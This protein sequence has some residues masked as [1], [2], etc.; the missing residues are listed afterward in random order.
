MLWA[1]MSLFA[2]H[3]APT[4]VVAGDGCASPW[5]PT[6]AGHFTLSRYPGQ[7]AVGPNGERP[8]P[9]SKDYAF[10]QGHYQMNGYPPLTITGRYAVTAADGPKLKVRFTET[11]FDGHPNPDTEAW[12]T[13]ADCGTAFEMDGMTYARV[14]AP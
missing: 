13:F 8:M 1:L 11:I 10:D 3:R 7:D 5:T 14:A 2:C 6:L 9:M 4:A 12:L